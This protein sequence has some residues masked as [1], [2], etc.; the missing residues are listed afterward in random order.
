MAEKNIIWNNSK[1]FYC[2]RD[3]YNTP[4]NGLATIYDDNI[5]S[6]GT[7]KDGKHNSVWT[8]WFKNGQK[9]KQGECVGSEKKYYGGQPIPIGFWTYWYESGVIMKQGGYEKGKGLISSDYTVKDGIWIYWDEDGN[10]IKE[11]IFKNSKEVIFTYYYEDGNISRKGRTEYFLPK[12]VGEN[13]YVGYQP[14]G[15]WTTWY[16]NGQ[17]SEECT[18]KRNNQGERLYHDL[19]TTWYKN[20]QKR[21]EVRYKWGVKVGMEMGWN[22]NGAIKLKQDHGRSFLGRLIE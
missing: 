9:Q 17:K 22:E 2:E 21:N 6:K 7:I 3:R 16:K 14:V 10:K 13:K 11:G 4:Y 5:K 1:H 12:L 18:Y 8:F 15:K 20:G 19:F